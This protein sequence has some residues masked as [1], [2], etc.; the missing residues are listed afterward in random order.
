M[1]KIRTVKP[2]V[3]AGTLVACDD[4]P[5]WPS[6]E[7]EEGDLCA[8]CPGS[9]QQPVALRSES[10]DGTFGKVGKMPAWSWDRVQSWAFPGCCNGC[11]SP[12]QGCIYNSTDYEHFAQFDVV[13]F[14]NNNL[15]QYG[16]GSWVGNDEHYSVVAGRG[17]KKAGGASK[18]A[19]PYIQWCTTSHRTLIPRPQKHTQE[20]QAH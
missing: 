12:W 11:T 16:N 13:L 20:T 7:A 17:I 2:S 4:A 3:A 6:Q 19:M 1:Q 18:P 8:V 14:Q 10:A 5:V 9:E 15:S